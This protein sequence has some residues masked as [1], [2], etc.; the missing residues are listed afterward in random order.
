MHN[1]SRASVRG[2]FMGDFYMDKL[3]KI[4]DVSHR[5]DVSART[6]RYY[7][8]MGLIESIR[9]DVYAYRLYDEAAVRKLEQVLIL[10]K[11]NISIKDIQMIFNASGTEAV[12][13]VLGKKVR[14][15]D[16]EVSLLHELKGFIL[17]F[18]RQ[19][20]QADFTKG[21]DVKML[22]EKAKEIEGRI[23]AAPENA[24]PENTVLDV[25]RLPEVLEQ[26]DR[27]IPNVTVVMLPGFR[28]VS[29]CD[30][31][32]LWGWLETRGHLCREDFWGGC[33]FYL[34]K[35]DSG[36]DSM[37]MYAVR[38][39]VTEADA[40]PFELI[41]VEGGMY[42]AA[43]YADMDGES[44]TST[45][46]K[47]MKWLEGTNFTHDDSR[48]CLAQLLFPH[49]DIKRGLGYHQMQQYIPIKFD[50]QD[51]QTVYSLATDAFIQ[52]MEHGA[53]WKG[54]PRRTIGSTGDP[55]YTF[56]EVEGRNGIHITNRANDWDGIFIL[57]DKL[58][59][60][61]NHYCTIEVRG[62]VT[63]KTSTL[64]GGRIE[65]TALPGYDSMAHHVVNAGEAFTLA[66]TFPVMRDRAL[67]T[68]R[69][70][71]N[72][73]A[74]EVPFMIEHIEITVKPFSANPNYTEIDRP[75]YEIRHLEAF[76]VTC[77]GTF[78]ARVHGE[79]PPIGAIIKAPA[80][81]YIYAALPQGYTD[82]AAFIEEV[83]ETYLPSWLMWGAGFE[84]TGE[85]ELMID[86]ALLL[87]V[88][89]KG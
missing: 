83:Y 29:G 66:H 32:A 63:D 2:G 1:A 4:R 71:S 88:V 49:S 36:M 5:Y 85:A 75:K 56:R 20:R 80:G 33:E 16:G 43:V 30:Y 44:Q 89:Q 84:L 7:E 18:I 11:L 77:D 42:A 62:R 61:P 81:R 68:L 25:S 76:E 17:E 34:N 24:A 10:R 51:W 47:I 78:Y 39:R 22:Y 86:N 67:P 31:N 55:D 41:T 48:D 27:R 19:I 87:S 6:L 74:R 28:A 13:A 52:S 38:D 46:A 59:I 3:I 53:T 50:T 9:T 57:L 79:T 82:T 21:D 23:T 12:L 70:T 45:H 35:E 54:I 15:I 65:M 73:L 60:Q 69:I 8:D 64:P 37:L 14:D 58:G 26:T 72:H 40:A